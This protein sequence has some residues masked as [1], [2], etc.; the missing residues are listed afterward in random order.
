MSAETQEGA[1][2]AAWIEG[3]CLALSVLAILALG[4]EA[5]RASYHGYLHTALGEAVLRGGLGPENPYHAGAPLRY[6]TLYPLLGVVIGRLGCGPLWGFAVL[7]VLSALILPSALD[8][9]GRSLGLSFR[10][11]RASFLAAVLGFNGL[12]WLGFLAPHAGGFGLPPVYS[13]MPMT[14]ARESFGW[15]ARLQAFLPKFLNV[16]SFTLALPFALWA[17]AECARF[18]GARARSFLPL[19]LGLALAL[20]LNPL[21]GG[22]AG[23]CGLVW[24][25]PDFWRAGWSR[26]GEWALAGLAAIGL[27]APFLVPALHLAP[28]GPSLTGKV[29]LGGNPWSNLFG[30]LLLLL[31][32][33]ALGLPLLP[34]GVRW[35]FLAAAAIAAALVLAGEM[36]QSNEY[37]MSRL[38]GLLWALPAGAWAARAAA[39]A[40][41]TRWIPIAL[42]LACV[43]TT[44]A[45]PWAYLMW[46][47]RAAELP[48]EVESGVLTPRSRGVRALMDA[49]SR[50]D[51]RAVVVMPP[52]FPGAQAEQGLV[53]GNAL[54]PALRHP[55][56]ADLP[57]IHND[58]HPDLGQRLALLEA[59]YGLASDEPASSA[60]ARMRSMLPDRPFLVFAEDTEPEPTRSLAE[61][62]AAVVA[63]GEGYGLWSLPAISR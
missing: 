16:S 50:A 20:A 12:G 40:T 30:P 3:A 4:G 53:Q 24:V 8:A 18:R 47:A 26:R 35:R 51:P 23:A 33:G 13:L 44:L 58:R 22:F 60:L 55:L 10:A 15:D 19:S 32:V 14:L 43:P 28:Q 36:P 38:S 62:G 48:L 25:A 41:R 63:R 49:E 7:D 9:L 37:K 27:A 54:A 52:S 5:V 61:A 59:A 34:A 31:P 42:A 39:S 57:Q 1:G 46:G 21:V 17:L 6:Y 45:V 29:A 2:R 11:R 56:F